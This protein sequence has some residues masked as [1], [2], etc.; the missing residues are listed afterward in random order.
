MRILLQLSM[1][2]T[3]LGPVEAD[4]TGRGGEGKEGLHRSCNAQKGFIDHVIIPSA[5]IRVF[6]N[7]TFLLQPTIKFDSVMSRKS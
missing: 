7:K 1:V 5:F 4:P 2:L 6:P 3:E